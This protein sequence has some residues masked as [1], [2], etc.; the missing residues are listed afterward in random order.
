MDSIARNPG[1]AEMPGADSLRSMLSFGS[2]VIGLFSVILLFY[3]NGFLIKR[4]KKELGLYSILGMEKIHIAKVLF[5]ETLFIAVISLA[6]GLFFGIAISKL[7]FLLLLN[8]MNLPSPIAFVVP[9]QSV[10]STS[11]LFGIIFLLTLLSNFWH[12]KIANPIT[13]LYGGKQGEREPKT[14]WAL[15]LIG[16]LTLGAGYYISLAVPSPIE[17]MIFFFLA[18]LLVIAGTYCLFTA[19]S[20]S[21]LKLLRSN[22]RFYYKPKNFIS[23]SGMIYRMKQNA[24][25]LASICILCT[26][27]LVTVSTTVSLYIGQEDI[28]LFRM[29]HDMKVTSYNNTENSVEIENLIQESLPSYGLGVKEHIAYRKMDLTLLRTGPASFASEIPDG[30]S[31]SYTYYEIILIPLADYNQIQKGNDSL[32]SGKAIIF[33][34]GQSYG[35]PSLTI[36]DTEFQVQEELQELRGFEK[37]DTPSQE[38]IYVI[39]E[40]ETVIESLVNKLYPSGSLKMDYVSLYDFEGTDEAQIAFTR[41]LQTK[42]S[43][44]DSVN[45]DSRPLMRER[46]FMDYGGFLFLGIFLG[47]LFLMATV[48]IIYYKQISEGYDDH[49]RFEIMQKVGMSR[50]EVKS[51]IHK[52]IVLVFFLP[53]LGAMLHIAFAFPVISK[54]LVVFGLT[55]TGLFLA[56]TAVTVFLFGLAYAA[57]YGL[58]ARAYY[59]LVQRKQV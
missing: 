49:D 36:D 10:V 25:G 47:F 12:I 28:L 56:C 2:V 21:V 40:N 5:F 59:Q 51:T 22:K 14:K 58:T 37:Y 48:L 42:L 27:V 39:L 33:T 8:I 6:L 54:M 35:Q 30:Y 46:W 34:N 13:L 9:T 17:A 57:V 3:T 52:Q 41:D 43:G 20:I 44:L 24:V 38:M 32:E 7:L 53:L 18:V 23:V 29:P 31:G 55:N 45:A 11:I 26:M 1:L 19:G 50:R 15:T 4:R 16:F